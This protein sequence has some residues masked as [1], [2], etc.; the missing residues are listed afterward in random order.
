MTV[1]NDKLELGCRLS[2][3]QSSVLFRHSVMSPHRSQPARL[4][5]PWDFPGKNTG[6]GCHCLLQGV[7]PD[8]RIEPASP[9]SAGDTGRFFTTDHLGS[10]SDEVLREMNSEQVSGVGKKKFLNAWTMMSI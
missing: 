5:G 7:F 10:P 2:I 9:A 6:V 3:T 4:L 8:P 1:E